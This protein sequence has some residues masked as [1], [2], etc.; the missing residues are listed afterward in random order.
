MDVPE[1]TQQG[2]I[3]DW[4]TDL[5]PAASVV[6]VVVV[7]LSFMRN[8]STE[9][10]RVIK[11]IRDSFQV[12]NTETTKAMTKSMDRNTTAIT[13]ACKQS[14]RTEVMYERIEDKLGESER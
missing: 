6:I 9:S 3:M 10:H 14:A 11:E 4:L 12:H 5:G 2:M 7:F 1:V 13:D 8:Y